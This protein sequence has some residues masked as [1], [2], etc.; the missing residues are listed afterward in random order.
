[1][2]TLGIDPGLKGGFAV[3]RNGRL[4]STMVM[5]VDGKEI[6]GVVVSNYLLMIDKDY[7]IDIIV[8]EHSQAIFGVGATQTFNFGRNI[9]ILEGV[10]MSLR[11]PFIKV[12][13]KVWQKVSWQGI[14]KM[15]KRGK[16]DTKGMSLVAT[17]RLFPNDDSL[18]L[19][20][21]RSRIFHEGIV[22]AVL[23]A[24]FYSRK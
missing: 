17:K 16:V 15:N 10:I 6:D 18:L 12:K 14:P 2:V 9:G 5:P 3:L 24:Y 19:A 22:D 20:T 4:V 11:I 7:G 8:L 13:P 21:S 1:M 23:M